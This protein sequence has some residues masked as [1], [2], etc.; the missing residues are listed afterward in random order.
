MN[1]YLQKLNAAK[2]DYP[3]KRWAASGLDQY[4]PDACKAFTRI[5]DRLIDELGKLGPA[6]D[7]AAKLAAFEQ[8]VLALNDLDDEDER[9][10]ETDEREQLCELVNTIATAAGLDPKDY[11]DGEGPATK[12]REW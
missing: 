12:W 3:F 1:D 4:T 7:E 9:L 6:A 5:F 10:I 2:A 11:G 8:A